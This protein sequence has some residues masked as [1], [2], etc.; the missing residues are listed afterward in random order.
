MARG[1]R[2]DR[3]EVKKTTEFPILTEPHVE[4]KHMFNMGPIERQ[5]SIKEIVFNVYARIEHSKNI[6]N[7]LSITVTPKDPKAE[8]AFM[9]KVVA[10]Y[11]IFPGQW[12]PTESD[13]LDCNKKTSKPLLNKM[14]FNL[15]PNVQ[16]SVKLDFEVVDQPSIVPRTLVDDVKVYVEEGKKLTLIGH[17][18]RTT[19]SKRLFKI[20]SR[21]FD[22]M[23]NHNM[24]EKQTGEVEM[25]DF[26]VKTLDAFAHFLVHEDIKDGTETALGLYLLSDKY[27]VPA[28]KLQTEKFI[29]DNL[30]EFDLNQVF[31]I[32]VAINRPLVMNGFFKNFLR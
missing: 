24:K 7:Y 12:C 9:V 30:K 16:I 21:A 15:N 8:V 20:R 1:G 11:D 14:G 19:V 29:L 22:S 13:S 26:D 18:G 31:D 4:L 17:D 28:L 6:G 3:E 2:S 23:F 32:F 5:V 25:S 10:S 27:D